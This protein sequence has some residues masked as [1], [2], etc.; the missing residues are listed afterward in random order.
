MPF[1]INE[2]LKFKQ[3]MKSEKMLISFTHILNVQLKKE[4]DAKLISNI[5]QEQK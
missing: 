4:M 2:I 3:F 5:L 1:E